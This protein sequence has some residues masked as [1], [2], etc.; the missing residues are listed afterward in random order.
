MAHSSPP[1]PGERGR[2]RRRGNPS[3]FLEEE[4]DWSRL[5]G[6]RVLWQLEQMPLDTMTFGEARFGSLI[7]VEAMTWTEAEEGM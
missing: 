6:D 4:Q 3:G 1:S 2:H 5:I 7:Q